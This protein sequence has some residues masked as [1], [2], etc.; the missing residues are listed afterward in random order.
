MARYPFSPSPGFSYSFFTRSFFLFLHT[1]I[2]GVPFQLFLEQFDAIP[3][4]MGPVSLE[5]LLTSHFPISQL[6]LPVPLFVFWILC[7]RLGVLKRLPSIANL[8]VFLFV[9]LMHPVF[10]L[11]R[12][13]SRSDFFLNRGAVVW[14]FNRGPLGKLIKRRFFLCPYFSTLFFSWAPF[15]SV[16]PPPN[17]PSA[18][19]SFCDGHA[20]V[21]S[22]TLTIFSACAQVDCVLI[23]PA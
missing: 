21:I 1:N 6:P 12:P 11:L 5:C 16:N 2:Y 23:R 3:L 19:R 13:F 7:G 9:S 22:V 4:P 17:P 14:A 10:F 15:S 20:K 18:R 8:A